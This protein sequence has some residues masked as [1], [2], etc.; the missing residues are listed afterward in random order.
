MLWDGLFIE[1]NGKALGRK[2][3]IVGNI[4]RPQEMFYEIIKH[5]FL[6]SLP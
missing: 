1:I 6:N 4:F 5:L 2:H 3:V